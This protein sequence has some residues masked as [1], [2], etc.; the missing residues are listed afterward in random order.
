M[1]LE[2][3]RRQIYEQLKDKLDGDAFQESFF[4]LE[5]VLGKTKSQMIT[6]SEE[7][8]TPESQVKAQEI[9]ALR[10]AGNPMAYI[11]GYK[12]FYKSRFLVNPNVLIPRPE[13]ELVVEKALEISSLS[14]IADLGCGSGCIGISILR[15]RPRT[16]LW[17]CDVSP[18]AVEVAK[19][20]AT[21]LGVSDRIIY[22]TGDVL[23]FKKWGEFDLIVSNPPY[24]DKTDERVEKNVRAFEPELALFAE[25]NGL[26]CY[27]QWIPWSVQALRP[28]G[29][30][31][32]EF[33]E[34]QHEALR[35]ICS[36]AGLMNIK[37]YKDFADIER[38]IVAEKAAQ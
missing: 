37:T 18:R 30:I 34:G 20:N 33:G 22:E 3:L 31:I 16:R 1:R 35:K 15:D 8:V 13:T 7:T 26:L 17:T 10:Q 25:E 36:D 9:V 23:A 32:F 19:Q 29:K 5:Y 2:A 12:D 4:I 6:D 27:K 21:Q 28:G 11:V 14:T 38:V 24:I